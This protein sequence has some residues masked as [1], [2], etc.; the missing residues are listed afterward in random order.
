VAAIGVRGGDFAGVGVL[1]NANEIF[2][3]GTQS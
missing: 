1:Q 3:G 2:S